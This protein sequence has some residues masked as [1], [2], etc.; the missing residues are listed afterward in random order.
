M[1]ADFRSETKETNETK[2][3]LTIVGVERV[4][5]WYFKAKS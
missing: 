3:Q 4:I 1:A 5:F 2:Q